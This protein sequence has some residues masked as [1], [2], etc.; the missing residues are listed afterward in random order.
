MLKNTILILVLILSLKIFSQNKRIDS[1]KKV[2]AQ[3]FDKKEK[4]MSYLRLASAV[5][6]NDIESYKKYT[7]SAMS[8]AKKSK[9]LEIELRA[10]INQGIYFK[11]RSD[12]QKSLALYIKVLERSNELNDKN[13]LFLVAS[14]N[15]ANLYTRIKE[16]KKAIE[17]AKKSLDSINSDTDR[18]QT[19]KASLFNSLGIS[20]SRLEQFDNALLSYNKVYQICKDIKAFNGEMTALNNIALIYRKQKNYEKAIG[21]CENILQSIKPGEYLR[22][23]ALTLLNSGVCYIALGNTEKAIDYLIRSKDISTKNGFRKTQMDCHLYLAEAYAEKGDYKTSYEEQAAY[24]K[25]KDDENNEIAATSKEDLRQELDKKIDVKQQT[26]DS[27]EASRKN[28]L[29]ISLISILLLTSL[30]FFHLKR[31]K[32][33]KLQKEQLVVENEILNKHNTS[34]KVKLKTLAETKETQRSP[35]KSPRS[36]T[37]YTKLSL[38]KEQHKAYM[39]TILD[40]MEKHKPYLDF[41]ISQTKLA[42]NL[43]MSTHHLTEVLS[44][45]LGKN[46]YDFINLYR[47][48]EAKIIIENLENH[49]IK[50]LAIAY[51]AGFKSKTSFNRVFKKHTGLT[52]SAYREQFVEQAST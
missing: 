17:I 31:K 45:S 12:Y 42:Q 48:N 50:M 51:K 16:Y 14:V 3:T 47:V 52:P 20:Y 2:I 41:E 13:E 35:I 24:D 26:I 38:T 49:D 25:L 15:L 9:L 33:L 8:L 19:I 28:I 46:F 10:T 40:Y 18:F 7:D 44:V 6:D 30:L 22:T 4:A 23:E 39:D 43:N 11:N 29:I 34:L 21:L 5:A 27:A 32:L 37:T 36:K 1:V